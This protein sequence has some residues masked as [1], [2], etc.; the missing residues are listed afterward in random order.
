MTAVQMWLADIL[1][2]KAMACLTSHP[3]TYKKHWHFTSL[4]KIDIDVN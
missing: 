4:I 3:R 2:N 1:I